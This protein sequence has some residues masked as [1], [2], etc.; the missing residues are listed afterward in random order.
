MTQWPEHLLLPPQPALIGIMLPFP[1]VSNHSLPY[2]K[3]SGNILPLLAL[4]PP[5]GGRDGLTGNMMPMTTDLDGAPALAA[6]VYVGRRPGQARQR[7]GLAQEALVESSPTGLVF[8][9]N[10]QVLQQF[11]HGRTLPHR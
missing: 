6:K 5:R 10:S 7:Y 3:R 9:G 4:L 8:R 11:F 1:A 2:S